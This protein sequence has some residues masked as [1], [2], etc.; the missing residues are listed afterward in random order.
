[1]LAPCM[2]VLSTSK[3]AA[4]VGVRRRCPARSR[5]RRP[6]PP[7]RRPAS[8]AAAGSAGGA[9]LS[10]GRV[11]QRAGVDR[12]RCGSIPAMSGRGSAPGPADARRGRARR[13]RRPP[14]SP[15]R[16][17]VVEAGGRSLTW[18]QLD[19]EVGRIATGLGAAGV[20][21]RPPGA[22]RDR[23]PDRVR[24]DVPRRAA[25][26]GR[27]RPGQP[28]L[29][30]R[31]AGPDD[32]RLRL[33]LVVADATTVAAVREAVGA[34]PGAGR[35]GATSTRP[36]RAGAVPRVVVV[37]ASRCRGAVATTTCAPSRPGRCRRCR[38]PRSS[39]RCSTPAARRAARAPR[40]SP[41]ARCSPTSSRSPGSSRR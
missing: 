4:D 27:R 12:P 37:G 28:R 20:R 24:D 5:P 16:L 2:T 31:R 6:R 39:R 38:T 34:C 26:P 3:N 30:R 1:M 23:Q 33:A 41:T 11:S 32:R 10:G 21:R 9:R 7:P 18:A 40:C 8:S 14:S 22:D 35:R 13:R 36:A 17:A 15:D 25:R 29:A 19:D